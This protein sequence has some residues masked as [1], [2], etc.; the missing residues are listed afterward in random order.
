MN[1]NHTSIPRMQLD[2]IL[3]SAGDR[4]LA[5]VTI[6]TVLMIGMSDTIAAALGY[7]VGSDG[8]LGG[9]VLNFAIDAGAFSFLLLYS[10]LRS[11]N[12]PTQLS[13]HLSPLSRQVMIV[14]STAA[15]YGLFFVVDVLD[16]SYPAKLL[17]I[18]IPVGALFLVAMTARMSAKREPKEH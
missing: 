18:A 6:A 13:D 17:L 15:A 9:R 1:Q 16:V 12:E 8:Q 4:K 5:M 14:V 11:R 10:L 3:T 2:R 7:V